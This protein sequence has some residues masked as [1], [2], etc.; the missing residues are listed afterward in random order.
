MNV[1]PDHEPTLIERGTDV[2]LNHPLVAQ[3]GI[4]NLRPARWESWTPHPSAMRKG[5]EGAYRQA[6]K[7][8]SIASSGLGLGGS[9]HGYTS[10]TCTG[11]RQMPTCAHDTAE[12]G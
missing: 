10:W 11:R 4:H 2:Y 7:L 6:E 3:R 1:S 9:M 8:A 5:G 12:A